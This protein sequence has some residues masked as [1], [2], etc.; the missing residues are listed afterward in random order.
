[1][2][3]LPKEY[4]HLYPAIAYSRT[5]QQLAPFRERGIPI[6]DYVTRRANQYTQR[7]AGQPVTPLPEDVEYGYRQKR[8]TA[9]N[10]MINAG[11]PFAQ[12]NQLLIDSGMKEP[13][14]PKWDPLARFRQTAA[15]G[16]RW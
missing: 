2:E 3:S 12:A 4:W 13:E 9:L 7:Y 16:R 6:P 8:A 14:A 10:R 1:M 15:G 5:P 11:I